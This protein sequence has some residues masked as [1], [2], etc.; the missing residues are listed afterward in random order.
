MEQGDIA[1]AT[2]TIQDDEDLEDDEVKPT[3]SM[4][5]TAITEDDYSHLEIQLYSNDG[6][7]FV[8][9]D[10]NL[11]EFP[12]CLAWMDCPP[13]LVDGQQQMIGVYA[14]YTCVC[15]TNCMCTMIVYILHHVHHNT[16]HIT[17]M[18]MLY[19]TGNYIAVGTF[20]P[21]IEI[22]NLDVLD[23]LEPTASLGGI[24]SKKKKRIHKTDTKKTMVIEYKKDSHEGAVMSLSWNKHYR[25]ALSSGSADNTVKIWVS[26]I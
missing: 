18:F 7:L 14:Y 23:P 21:T 8:H 16:I 22:W 12:L 13:F 24:L 6:A 11:P 1:L 3:D 5:I 15:I 20:D 2:D 17:I 25:Q 10:I 4:I 19:T 9:H 26:N